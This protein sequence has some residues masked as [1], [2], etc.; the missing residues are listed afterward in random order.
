MVPE[1]SLEILPQLT[2]AELAEL[3]AAQAAT[4]GA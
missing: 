2:V 3:R 4:G 1:Y